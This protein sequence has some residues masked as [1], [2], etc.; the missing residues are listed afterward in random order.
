MSVGS[1][2]VFLVGWLGWTLAVFLSLI[3]GETALLVVLNGGFPTEA[4]SP[5]LSFLPMFQGLWTQNPGGALQT[6]VDREMLILRHMHPGS[7]IEVWGL[8]FYPLTVAVLAAVS[9]VMGWALGGGWVDKPRGTLTHLFVGA[10]AL[11]LAVTYVR[12]ASCCSGPAWAVDVLL[13]ALTA[14]SPGT[15]LR[16]VLDGASQAAFLAVQIL[17][18]V[19]GL[20][21]LSTAP[22]RSP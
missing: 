12:V 13:R 7:G 9:G 14:S 22:H 19:L 3:F 11:L 21:M 8:Y 15:A 18:A 2:K 4:E 20:V 16:E 1:K 5:F 10:A 17:L 6:L